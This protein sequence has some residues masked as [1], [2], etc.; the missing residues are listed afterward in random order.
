MTNIEAFPSRGTETAWPPRA[1]ARWALALLF[2]AYILSFV[3]R[4]IL[5]ILV[6]PISADLQLSDVQFALVGGVAFA[7]FYV[8]V[9][10]PIGWLA[11][12]MSRRIIVAAGISLWSLC[13]ILSGLAPSFGWLFLARMGVGVGEAA[14]AP[15]AY[16]LIADFF[17]VTRRGR[18]VAFYTL[19][20]SIGSAIAYLAGG[21]LIGFATQQGAVC[22]PVLG[23]LAPWRFVFVAAGL[24]GIVMAGL[25][26]TMREPPRRSFA[27]QPSGAGHGFIAFLR[28]HRR[29][30]IAYVA[31]Y[32]FLNL[33]FAGFLLWGPALFG[34][35]HG[36]GPAELALPFALIFLVAAILGQ[37][38]GA[39]FTDRALTAGRRDAP[40]RTAMWC[41]VP[42][43]PVAVA[44]PLLD[45]AIAALAALALLLFLTCASIGHHAVVAA[46]V[47]PN[48][49][50]GLYVALFFFVQNVMGQAIIAL[51]TGFL[52][53]R[54]FGTPQSIG[55][56]MAIVGGLGAA[57]GL[58]LLAHGRDALRQTPQT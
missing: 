2:V 58:F 17:P 44:M 19:G 57:I 34:R 4:I 38:A 43:V 33:P 36:L 10:L 1:Q 18:A 56:S 40:F 52:T 42:L 37:W 28:A 16:S 30:S 5:S 25:M 31:G 8:T 35:V 53:D 32:S 47:A 9:G 22:L 27:E 26:L 7:L 29:V 24:P 3:D 20:A 14:L 15:A 21:Q 48:R 54:V 23:A 46:M 11:D 49:L 45:N 51:I 50:R 13:T 12:R 6:R 41:A 55:L 39:T